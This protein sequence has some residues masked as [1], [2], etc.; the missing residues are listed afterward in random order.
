MNPDSHVGDGDV[1]ANI[2]YFRLMF[3]KGVATRRPDHGHRPSPENLSEL[4]LRIERS[5]LGDAMSWCPKKPDDGT[6]SG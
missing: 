4:R 3:C 5:G 6:K 1:G 2:G